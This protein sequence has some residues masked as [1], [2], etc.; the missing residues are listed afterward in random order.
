MVTPMCKIPW[1]VG[2][3]ARCQAEEDAKGGGVGE[4]RTEIM[5]REREQL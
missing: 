4:P 1:T 5:H 3:F 2:S